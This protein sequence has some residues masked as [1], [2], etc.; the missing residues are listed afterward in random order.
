VK[1]KTTKTGMLVNLIFLLCLGAITVMIGTIALGKKIE[2]LRNQQNSG[3]VAAVVKPKIELLPISTATVDNVMVSPGAHVAT[4]QVLVTLTNAS[5]TARIAALSKFPNISSAV[6]KLAAAQAQLKALTVRAPNNGVVGPIYIAP[7]SSVDQST[8]ILDMYTDHDVRLYAQLTLT[9]Y[10]HL[11]SI[12]GLVA[13]SA[14]L[15]RS[16]PVQLGSLNPTEDANPGDS[17]PRL[18]MY[19]QLTDPTVAPTLLNNEALQLRPATP[20]SAAVGPL[21]VLSDFWK[22]VRSST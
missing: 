2:A 8:P 5:L 11:R 22:Q 12:H 15:H 16:F 4:G 13:Y 1:R 17:Q 18:G 3:L 10:Q 20:P 7:G 14:R 6:T 9:D 21:D 19:L